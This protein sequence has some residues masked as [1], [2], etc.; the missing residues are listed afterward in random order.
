MP[1]TSVIQQFF[2]CLSRL[3]GGGTGRGSKFLPLNFNTSF[4]FVFHKKR[5]KRGFIE[6]KRKRR[7]S[8]IPEPNSTLPNIFVYAIDGTGTGDRPFRSGPVRSGT[9]LDFGPAGLPFDRSFAVRPVIRRSTG[10]MPFDRSFTV[11]P[12]FAVRPVIRRSTGH[13]P[14]DRSFITEKCIK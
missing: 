7:R 13:L 8:G 11:R 10:L 6:E 9:G 4:Q 14:F 1:V 3:W 12:V 2:M 5:P